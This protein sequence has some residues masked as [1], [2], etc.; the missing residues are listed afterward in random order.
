MF[1]HNGVV[2]GFSQIKRHILADLDERA[3]D[4]VQSFHSD[5][6]IA[7]ALFLH[8][9]GLPRD[10]HA[11]VARRPVAAVLTALEATIQHLLRL[12]AEH[13]IDELS[14]MNFV[15]SDGSAV[16]ACKFVWPPTA[17]PSSLYYTEGSSFSRQQDLD[18]LCCNKSKSK[19]KTT[20][21]ARSSNTNTNTNTNTITTSNTTTTPAAML[22]P[23]PGG[24]VAVPVPLPP[25]CRPSPDRAS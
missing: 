19:G 7:F 4:S 15:V 3:F 21:G 12:Q 10:S 14:L 5:S 23:V 16:V 18:D 22:V 11:P 1:M 9:L 25:P 13:G 20:N 2:G 8:H 24:P 6:A 17:K